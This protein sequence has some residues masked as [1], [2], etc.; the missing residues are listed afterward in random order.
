[1]F[2]VKNQALAV[3]KKYY[4]IGTVQCDWL[5][6]HLTIGLEFKWLHTCIILMSLCHSIEFLAG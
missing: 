4:I 6:S 3:F 2:Q 1:M 5:G